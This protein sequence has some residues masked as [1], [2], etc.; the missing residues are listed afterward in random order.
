MVRNGIV[1]ICVVEKSPKSEK[2][3]KIA[4]EFT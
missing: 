4:T 2:I 1:K 3:A